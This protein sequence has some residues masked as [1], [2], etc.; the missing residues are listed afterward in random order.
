M[1]SAAQ[2]DKN[3]FVCVQKLEQRNIFSDILNHSL[4]SNQ[5]TLILTEIALSKSHKHPDP[6]LIQFLLNNY[7]KPI[8]FQIKSQIS[9]RILT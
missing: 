8:L 5:I 7:L 1:M 6:V 2:T 4:E 9:G 3:F